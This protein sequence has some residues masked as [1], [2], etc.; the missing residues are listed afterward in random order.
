MYNFTFPEHYNLTAHLGDS[1]H[2]HDVVSLFDSVAKSLL[3]FTNEHQAEYLR[4]RYP[5][6][7]P[8]PQNGNP[9][10]NHTLGTI[11]E[12]NY[13]KYIEFRCRYIVWISD[14]SGVLEPYSA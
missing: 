14:H 3:Y 4:T 7:I 8:P 1:R 12:Y 2:R 13:E 9:P 11:F 10:S 6:L 5:A